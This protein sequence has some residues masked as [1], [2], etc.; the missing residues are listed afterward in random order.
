MNA[1]VLQHARDAIAGQKARCRKAYAA[2]NEC[3]IPHIAFACWG[4]HHEVRKLEQ[5][6]IDLANL[7]RSP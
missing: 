2:A 1:F 7:E 4:Y 6:K 5:M 3:F